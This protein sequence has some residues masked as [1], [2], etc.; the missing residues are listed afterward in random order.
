MS[1]SATQRP[2]AIL[3]DWDGTLVDTLPGLRRAHNHVRV[4]YGLEA[5]DEE[6]FTSNLKFSARELY[7]RIYGDK[8]Q[9]AMDTLYAFVM[10]NHLEHLTVL[11]GAEALIRFLRAQDIPVGLVSNKRHEV[12]L[13]EVSHL[14]WNDLFFCVLGAGSA[15]RD[16]PWAD[17]ILMALEK[18]LQPLPKGSAW[19]VGDNET[20]LMAARDSGCPAILLTHGKDRKN[21]VSQYSPLYVAHDCSALADLL[22]SKMKAC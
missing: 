5:W 9:A 7:P 22:H 17:P 8:A 3:F 11:P 1:I 6:Q 21:L 10:E 12:L 16:K 18:A 13:R 15:A 20:D 19:Y 2:E 4:L 14:G